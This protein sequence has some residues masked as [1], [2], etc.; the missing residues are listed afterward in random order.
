MILPLSHE[1]SATRRLP[2]VTLSIMALCFLVLLCSDTSPPEVAGDPMGDAAAYWRDHA[3]LTPD[4]EVRDEVLSGVPPAERRQFLTALVEL[5]EPLRPEDA[6]GL[7]AQ[8]AELDR[9]SDLA[10]GRTP[11]DPSTHNTFQRWGYTPAEPRAITLITSTFVHAGWMHLLGNLFML[12]LAGPAIEDRWGRLLYPAFFLLAGCVSAWADAWLGNAPNVPQ[13][14]ASG[15]IAG[16]MG[17]FLVRLWKTRIRFAYFFVLGFRPIYGT[18]EAAAWVM[19]PLWFANEL[20]QA[21][22]W[23]SMDL[24]SGVAYWAHVGGFAFGAAAAAGV[25]ASRF[26]ERFVDPNVEARI[27]HYAANPVL[28]Q[29]MEARE[30]GDLAGALDALEAEWKRKPDEDLANA[31]WDTAL[32][33]AKPERGAP[34]LAGALRAALKR[35]DVPLALQHYASLVE[36]APATRVDAVTLLRLAPALAEAGQRERA[37]EALRMAVDG[38]GAPP[39]GGTLARIMDLARDLDP[40]AAMRAARL[41]LAA[42]D[43][44]EARR[45]KLQAFV[46]ELEQKGVADAPD[47]RNAPEVPERD[48]A[49]PPP[50]PPSAVAADGTVPMSRFAR[51]K[52]REVRPTALDAESLRI[53]V[54]DGSERAMRLDKIQ[55]VAAAIVTDLGPRPVLVIDLLSNWN[56]SEAEELRGVRLRSDRFDPRKLLAD[57]AS[58]PQRAF[59]AFVGRLLAASRGAP[60]PSPEAALGKLFARFAALADY[61]RDV[62]EVAG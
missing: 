54:E 43:L 27:T 53:A 26:E 49:V 37:A 45:A 12:L 8:Q 36:H 28:E 59:A 13:V 41:A 33:C 18:F 11:P 9:L 57:G 20:F 44:H 23:S 55:G 60:L 10:L 38:K 46:A 16:V 2:W 62:L 17:A 3:Y 47:T 32:A 21:A 4:P 30:R 52:L 34:A 42:P 22:V 35:D 6:E 39:S 31:L 40:V 51:A 61:E 25:R 7:A 29:A 19:L 56:E 1:S 24:A 5:S 48:P 58:D 15:A 50:L 14:G